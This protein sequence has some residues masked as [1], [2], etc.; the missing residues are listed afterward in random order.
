MES[1]FSGVLPYYSETSNWN[2]KLY[3]HRIV[4]IGASFYQSGIMSC[5]KNDI[6]IIIG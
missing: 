3:I 5:I 2:V 6:N 1:L 4:K